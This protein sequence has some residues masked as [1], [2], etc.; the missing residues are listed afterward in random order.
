MQI[1]VAFVRFKCYRRE[2]PN[3]VVAFPPG[4][5]RGLVSRDRKL[6]RIFHLHQIVVD[7]ELYHIM[8][9]TFFGWR[10]QGMLSM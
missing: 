8:R 3:D 2:Q 10:R 1:D 5:F 6:L 9:S 7:R 4:A